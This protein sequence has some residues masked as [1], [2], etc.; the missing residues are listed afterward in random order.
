MR[1]AG[2]PLGERPERRTR[3]FCF[4]SIP[5]RLYIHRSRPPPQVRAGRVER[6]SSRRRACSRRRQPPARSARG[7]GRGR[8]R[9]AVAW[10][11]GVSGVQHSK[12]CTAAISAALPESDPISALAIS[13]LLSAILSA[14]PGQVWLSRDEP[15]C[16]LIH[17]ENLHPSQGEL[18]STSAILS[19]DP[20]SSA[21]LADPRYPIRPDHRLRYPISAPIIVSA[22]PYQ[23]R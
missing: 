5:R 16:H 15:S 10:W 22:I 2:I 6:A 9:G 4:A 8:G 3:A 12:A 20:I 23:L 21:I 7:I 1:D 19:A 17:T 13:A 18:Y 14:V 11:L